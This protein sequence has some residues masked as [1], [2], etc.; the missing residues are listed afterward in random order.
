L[1]AARSRRLVGSID[2]IRIVATA[3]IANQIQLRADTLGRHSV[4]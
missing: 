3:N 1:A 4:F 2:P